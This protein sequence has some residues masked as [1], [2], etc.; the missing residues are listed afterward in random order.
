MAS[1][2]P[3]TRRVTSIVRGSISVESLILNPINL[4]YRFIAMLLFT[5]ALSGFGQPFPAQSDATVQNSNGL[6]L[7]VVAE[8]AQ[9]TLRIVLPGRASSDRSIEVLFPEHVT[10]IK[11]GS[12]VVEHL[13]MFRPG[14]QGEPVKWRRAGR[15][16]EYQRDLTGGVHLLARATLED[17]GVRF[18]YQFTNRSAVAYDMIYAVTDPRLT[19]IFHDVRL[20]RTYVHHKNGF[21][22]LA[23][24]TPSRLTIPLGEWLPARY[25]VSF[26]WP[27]PEERVEHR[28]DRI[29]YYNKSR[30]VDVPFIATFSLDRRWLVASFSRE[31]GNVWSNPELTC[32]HVDPQM[33][34]QPGQQAGREVKILIVPGSLDDA[35]RRAISQRDAL[36]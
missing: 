21:D 17:D 27:V 22:L 5:Y 9:P 2:S 12:N 33:S 28:S 18:L 19:S 29:T 35:L 7:I 36:K 3:L 6:Q 15:S 1:E 14:P 26:T 32:Q 10:A 23:S 30:A 24:E 4:L 16:L 8:N 25:L 31:P 13:Y 20:E 34:L 11:Q